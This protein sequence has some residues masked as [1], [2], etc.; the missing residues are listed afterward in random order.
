C[1][2][3][4]SRNVCGRGRYTFWY[5]YKAHASFNGAAPPPQTASLRHSWTYSWFLSSAQNQTNCSSKE[6]ILDDGAIP[7]RCLEIL[8][9]MSQTWF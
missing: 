9:E 1:P 3:Q 2:F 6:P 7:Y 5:L 4:S 8:L